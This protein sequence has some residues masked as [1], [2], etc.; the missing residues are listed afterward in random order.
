MITL[1]VL[2]VGIVSCSGEAIPGG[3]L[4]RIACRRVLDQMRPGETVTICLPL[5]IAGGKEERDFASK[6]PTIT[7]DGC[8]KLC[9][10]KST[11]KLSGKPTKSLII[12]DILRKHGIQ[13]PTSLRNLRPEEK[14]AAQVVAEEIA[15][16]VDEVL[17]G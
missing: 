7:V 1:E 3:T 5:F 15:R 13:P 10:R 4:S 11:E 9:A 8:E 16:T 12:P 6:Y 17:G 14:A 2:K